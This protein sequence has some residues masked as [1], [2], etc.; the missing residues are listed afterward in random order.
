MVHS[1]DKYTNFFEIVTEVLQGDAVIPFLFIIC[2]DYIL[3]IL[4]ALMKG[5][6]FMLNVVAPER[7]TNENANTDIR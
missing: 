1:P 3:Q 6:G 2:S 4:I 5:N 7:V